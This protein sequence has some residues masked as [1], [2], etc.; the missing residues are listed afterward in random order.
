M[1]A[2]VVHIVLLKWKPGVTPEQVDCARR[3]LLGLREAIPGIVE[4]TCGPNFTERSQG[5]HFGLV[6][7]FTHRH[8]LE[9]YLPHPAHRAVVESVINPIRES[10]LALDYYL[11]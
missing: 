6:V 11:R 7:R 5:Y 10:S 4:L 1:D 9:E 8:A 3:A 2:E